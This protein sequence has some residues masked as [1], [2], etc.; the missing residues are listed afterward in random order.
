MT[1]WTRRLGSLNISKPDNYYNRLNL[2]RIESRGRAGKYRTISSFIDSVDIALDEGLRISDITEKDKPLGQS[3]EKYGECLTEDR[4]LDFGS[5][6]N[7]LVVRL[8]GDRSIQK[9]LQERT[10]FLVVDEYQD[11]NALQERLIRNVVGKNTK[12]AVVGDDDQSIYAW[13]G[14]VVDNILLNFSNRYDNV[15]KVRLEDNFRSSEGIV[16]LANGYIKLNAAR[17]RKKMNVPDN[18]KVTTTKHDIEYKHFDT[19]DEQADF[20]APN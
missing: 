14:A 9:A 11:I 18:S 5:M 12:I 2:K 1:Y 10:R 8:E 7:E 3:L 20:I 6:I 17:L 19:E 15:Q 16:G 4:Y 13:R